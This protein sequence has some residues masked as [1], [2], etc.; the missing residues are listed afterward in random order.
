MDDEKPPDQCGS[1][2]AAQLEQIAQD[3]STRAAE[4]YYRIGPSTEVTHGDNVDPI[5]LKIRDATYRADMVLWSFKVP[6]SV[7]VSFKY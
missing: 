6:V 7:W 1:S 3:Y 5:V 4:E 2:L